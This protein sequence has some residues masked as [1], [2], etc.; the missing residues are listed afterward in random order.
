MS[1]YKK[2]WLKL[3]LT[4]SELDRIEQLELTLTQATHLAIEHWQ[5]IDP[6]ECDRHIRLRQH[7]AIDNPMISRSIGANKATKAWTDSVDNASL[8]ASAAIGIWL[9]RETDLD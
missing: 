9:M 8:T 5:S 1:T 2:S 3:R 6:E 7:L 4:Q